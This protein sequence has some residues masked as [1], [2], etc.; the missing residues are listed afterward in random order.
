MKT[1][2]KS[3]KQQNTRFVLGAFLAVA[4][5]SSINLFLQVQNLNVSEWVA[6]PSLFAWLWLI[7]KYMFSNQS[8]N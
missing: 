5:P 1:I 7:S 6:Y 8:D 4:I 3:K 2:S